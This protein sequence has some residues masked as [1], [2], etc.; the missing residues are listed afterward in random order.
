LALQTNARVSAIAHTPT[1][2]CAHLNGQTN[3]WG[4]NEERSAIAF[5]WSIKRLLATF[6]N[7]IVQNAISK[8]LVCLG[9]S[10]RGTRYADKKIRRVERRYSAND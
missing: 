6:P 10:R 4:S 3:D 2:G 9:P 8:R 7:K 5:Q 1:F